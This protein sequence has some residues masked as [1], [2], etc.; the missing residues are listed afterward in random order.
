MAME[1]WPLQVLTMLKGCSGTNKANPALDF[2]FDWNKFPLWV[3]REGR[4]LA[5][6]QGSSRLTGWQRCKKTA[7]PDSFSPLKTR[8]CQR[9]FLVWGMGEENWT[10]LRR[11]KTGYMYLSAFKMCLVSDAARTWGEFD[12]RI[13]LHS[14][15]ESLS[16]RLRGVL[17]NHFHW[18]NKWVPS[19][20]K[21]WE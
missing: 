18:Y 1:T 11:G 10:Q 12:F 4:A 8:R 7:V 6:V 15:T 14:N 5:G 17:F 21:F 13:P 16:L 20:S 3:A 2:L 9:M 19:F